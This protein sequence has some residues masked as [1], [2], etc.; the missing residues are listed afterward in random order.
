MRQKKGLRLI[1]R[2]KIPRVYV[3]TIMC[4]MCGDYIP[5]WVWPR[6]YYRSASGFY[7]MKCPH[8]GFIDSDPDNPGS[9]FNIPRHCPWPRE[10]DRNFQVIDP[11]T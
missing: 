2:R 8:C 5:L 10:R 3:D 9:F 4:W 7:K 6:A 1:N 11:R